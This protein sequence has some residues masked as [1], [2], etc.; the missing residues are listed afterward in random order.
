MNIMKTHNNRAKW[1][2]PLLVTA[3]LMGCGGKKGI[4]GTSA[5]AVLAPFVTSTM[6]T[7]NLSNVAVHNPVIS[8]NLNE[9]VAAGAN[10]TVTCATPCVN[11]AGAVSLDSSNKVVTFTPAANLAAMT[12]YTATVTSAKSVTT[13]LPMEAPFVWHF[14]TG[15]APAALTVTAV[16]PA[17]NAIGVSLNTTQVSADFSDQVMPLMSTASSGAASFTLT[18]A[19]PCTNPTGTVTRDPSNKIAVYTLT[20]ASVLE[21]QT[22]YTATLTGVTAMTTGA[23]LPTFTWHFKTG[24]TADTTRPTI[25]FTTPA[26]TIPGPTT[27][28][29]NNMAISAVF[30]EAMAPATINMNSFTVT[31]STPCVSPVGSVSYSVGTK[32]AVF[33]PSAPLVSNMTYTAK[34]TMAATDLAGNM[35]AGNQASL[36]AASDYV[37]TFTTTAGTNAAPISVVS[38]NPAAN[39]VNVCPGATINAT[40]DIPSGARLNPITV[41]SATFTVMEATTAKTSVVA[42]SVVVD[43]ATGHIAT[44]TPLNALVVGTSYTAT[45]KSGANGV[46]DLA[47]PANAM[48]NDYVWTFTAASCAVTN[49]S[50]IPLGSAATFGAFGGSAGTTNQGI[51]T[52]I[53]GDIGTTAVST[54]VTGFH[55]SGVGCTYTETTLNVGTVNGKIYT[56]APPPTVGCPTEGT[57]VT[58]AVAAAA[59]NDA[60]IAYNALVAKPAGTDPGAGN[61]AN[62]VLAPGVYTSA[63]GS[64][65]IQGGN[66]TLDA[67]GNANATWVFQMASS[68][69][70]GGPGA[71]A[72]QS[73][74]LVN[75]AQ[76][77][78]VFWQVGTAAT[79]NAGGGGTMMGTIISQ[80]GADISTSGNVALVTLNGRVLSL[81]AS[82]TMVN[83]VINVPAQ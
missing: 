50:A 23:L 45:L 17:A 79:I 2:V 22:D 21:A 18:C 40:F 83:T 60:L 49:S 31:C 77:K 32:T 39:A 3:A 33:T 16:A 12:L 80:A 43:A 9:S 67:Q 35:L 81:N 72:P 38:T 1:L 34:V 41:N 73:I 54:A 64:F 65:M 10:L 58:A 63:S 55:D 8:A 13:G 68:L 69:T 36:P 75:G 30:S 71:A 37:W 5:N 70:V 56:S 51:F 14:T 82:V 29:P 61:L 11:P 6:P 42:A 66:L 48:S 26:T 24:S 47:I 27:G 74:T 52:V 44:F 4:L 57:A 15:A 7:D 76:A 78:N 28:V 59:R 20:P 62:L 53:N 46:K 19:S 25:T